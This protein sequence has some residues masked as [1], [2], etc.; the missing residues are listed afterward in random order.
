MAKPHGAEERGH[1]NVGDGARHVGDLWQCLDSAA[2]KY[3]SVCRLTGDV[4]E[5]K[6]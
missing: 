2:G 4:A 6:V 3:M 1:A 5:A